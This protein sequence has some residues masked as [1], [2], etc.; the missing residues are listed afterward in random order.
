MFHVQV[1]SSENIFGGNK[2]I[3]GPGVI[4]KHIETLSNTRVL[5]KKTLIEIKEENIVPF[6]RANAS[7]LLRRKPS[8]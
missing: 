1:K 5:L 2:T 4:V 7:T 3:E 8:E 6:E